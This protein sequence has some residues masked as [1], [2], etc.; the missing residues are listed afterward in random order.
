MARAARFRD[1]V[2][3][4]PLDGLLR[5]CAYKDLK[6]TPYVQ[7]AWQMIMHCLN[8]S[9]YHRGQ[10]VTQMRELGLED[11]PRTDLIHFQRTR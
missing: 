3:T 4:L 7:Q 11:I 9:S 5:E 2:I 1:H 6:G 10:V 8:H